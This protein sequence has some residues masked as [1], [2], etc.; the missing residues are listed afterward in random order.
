MKNIFHTLLACLTLVF[1]MASCSEAEEGLVKVTHYATFQLNDAD[2]NN[3]TLVA[4][5]DEYVDPGCVCMEGDTD[6]S[7]KVLVSGT[8]DTN[9]MGVYYVTYSA[10]N[11]DGFASSATRTVIVY[12]P[13]SLDRDISGTY[14]VADGSYRFWL[15]TE[16]KVN[17]SGYNVDLDYVAPGLYHLSDY[18]GGYYDQRAGYGSDYAMQGY[19]ALNNDNTFSAITADVAGWGDSADDVQGTY[20][21]AT[22]SINLE[23][24]YAGQMIFYVTLNK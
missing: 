22:G 15:E 20:D 8:V 2:A 3:V 13:A 12:N 4:V 14:T 19:V 24:A 5:G 10:E 17:F 7:D 9:A 1:A 18:M 21:E 23:V 11:K 16:G 6:I